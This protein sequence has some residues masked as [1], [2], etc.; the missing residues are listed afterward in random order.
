[1]IPKFCFLVPQKARIDRDQKR[2]THDTCA[3]NNQCCHSLL[4][5]RRPHKATLQTCNTDKILSTDQSQHKNLW[6]FLFRFKLFSFK[7]RN[8]RISQ[9]SSGQVRGSIPG[10]GTKGYTNCKRDKEMK[11]QKLR[12]LLVSD[13]LI[14]QPLTIIGGTPNY[15]WLLLVQTLCAL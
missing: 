7:E 9:Q 3:I 14:S 10:W 11:A 2:Q 1:M 15:M 13:Q 4:H 6:P 5:S 8:E 12:I